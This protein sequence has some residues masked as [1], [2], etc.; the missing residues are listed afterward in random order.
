MAIGLGKM[1]G[2]D[3]PENFDYPYISKSRAGYWQRW[4]ISL[5]N[6]FRDYLYTPLFRGLMNI[7]NPVTRRPLSVKSCDFISL[8]ITW[9]LV[10]IWHGSELQFVVYGLWWFFFIMI[11]RLFTVYSK[12]K[13]KNKETNGLSSAWWYNAL[14][15]VYTLLVIIFALVFFRSPSLGYAINYIMNMVGFHSHVLYDNTAFLLI[16]QNLIFLVFGIIFSLPVWQ[17]VKNKVPYFQKETAVTNIISFI[18]YAGLLVVS[19]AYVVSTVPKPF[20]YFQF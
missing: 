20:I 10:G 14:L 15:H 3:L 6:W 18:G 7:T 16:K 5:S 4:H 12:K 9:L 19:I 17:F 13:R 8:F 1:F 2:F 11:E